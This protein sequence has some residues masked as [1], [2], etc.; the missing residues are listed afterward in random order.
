MDVNDFLALALFVLAITCGP[1]VVALC[2]ALA[3][4]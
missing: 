4:D 3:R 2:I 1:V